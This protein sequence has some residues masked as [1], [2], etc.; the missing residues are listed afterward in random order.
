MHAGSLD[1]ALLR[2]GMEVSHTLVSSTRQVR[3][4]LK[5]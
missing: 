2:P 3:G 4:S 5:Q 1:I